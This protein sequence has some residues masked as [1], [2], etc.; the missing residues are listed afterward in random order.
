MAPRKP[1][2]HLLV[3]AGIISA[4][5]LERVLEVQK[6]SGKRLGALLRDMGI[7]TEEEIVEA[8]ARQYNLKTIRNFADHKFPKEL[9]ALVPCSLAL[10]K[11]IFPLKQY[12]GMLAI[13]TLDPLDHAT[14]DYLADKTGMHIYLAL[15]T[16]EEIF[17]AIRKHYLGGKWAKSG[18]QKILL[19]DS[20]PIVTKYLEVPLVREGYEVLV[21]NDGVEGLKLAF[22]SPPDLIVCDLIMPG[23]D[24]YNFLHAVKAHPEMAEIPVILMASKAPVEEEHRALEAG[25]VDFIGKPAMPVRVL[26]R[27]KMAFRMVEEQRQMFSKVENR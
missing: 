24:G 11:L 12:D 7:V 1:I 5:T 18:R 9:L 22:S 4:K 26:A 15:A 27:I 2:G 23:M 21:A 25:F 14:F 19:V 13:A 6:G 17:A 8:L 16:R 3:E 10:A 20:S